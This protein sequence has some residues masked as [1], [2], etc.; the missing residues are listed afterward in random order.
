MNGL[1][2][3]VLVAANG[4]QKY[5]FLREKNIPLEQTNTYE[6]FTGACA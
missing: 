5:S 2:I 3:Q 4:Q 1:L 6:N